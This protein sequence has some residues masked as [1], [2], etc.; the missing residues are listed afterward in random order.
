MRARL[1]GTEA[2]ATT[3]L[4]KVPSDDGGITM[5]MTPMTL[6]DF[7][8]RG[9]KAHMGKAAKFL[10][11]LEPLTPTVADFSSPSPSTRRGSLNSQWN[12]TGAAVAVKPVKG[13]SIRTAT[14]DDDLYVVWYPEV[15]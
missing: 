2:R 7:E 15:K 13:G 10:L 12:G 11:G 8:K 3:S 9:S 5:K 4:P 6:E 1:V 14:I